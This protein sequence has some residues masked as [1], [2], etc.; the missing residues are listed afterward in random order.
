MRIHLR[1]P[2][3]GIPRHRPEP[4]GS[5]TGRCSHGRCGYPGDGLVRSKSFQYLAGLTGAGLLATQHLQ[6]KFETSVRACPSNTEQLTVTLQ[7][8][9]C[10][11]AVMYQTISN[12]VMFSE[13]AFESDNDFPDRGD[14][15]TDGQDMPDIIDGPDR[16]H[17]YFFI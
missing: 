3:W 5:S 17:R 7:E 13:S 8:N 4:L 10:G 9:Y 14:K 15:D 1:P 6:I 11:E 12:L 16:D 2:I